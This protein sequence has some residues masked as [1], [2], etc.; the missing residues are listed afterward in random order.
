MIFWVEDS[1]SV[2]VEGTSLYAIL[3]YSRETNSSYTNDFFGLAN[4]LPVTNSLES[5]EGISAGWNIKLYLYYSDIENGDENEFTSLTVKCNSQESFDMLQNSPFFV[6][7]R[8]DYCYAVPLNWDNASYQSN[9]LEVLNVLSTLLPGGEELVMHLK[10]A[11][12]AHRPE[13]NL[14]ELPVVEQSQACCIS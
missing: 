14:L 8:E 9:L 11:L 6:G 10:R 3:S 13:L 7:N 1:R 2:Q 5:F 12:Q 4:T